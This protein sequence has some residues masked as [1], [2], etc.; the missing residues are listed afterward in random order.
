MHSL[1]PA[2]FKR[3][4]AAAALAVAT[5]LS[6]GVVSTSSAGAIALGEKATRDDLVQVKIFDK[7]DG[8]PHKC[9][10]TAIAPEWV[11]TA[12][13]CVE[14]P[15]Y[16][17]PDV[18]PDTLKIHFSNDKANPGPSIDVD[19]FEKAPKADIALLHLDTPK[20]LDKYAHI[21]DDHKYRDGEKVGFYGFGKGFKDVDV[22]WLH[23]ARMEVIAQRDNI[24]A[25]EVIAM[26]GITGG[27]NHGDSGGPVFT[28]DGQLIAV[29]VMGSHSV[30][31]D[32]YAESEAVYLKYYRDWIR[33]TA[34]V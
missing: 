1:I 18:S 12:A 17:D 24:N 4:C 13:H 30:W 5:A 23:K 9:T 32:P 20:K 2:R 11:L 31:F 25:G 26:Y 22:D 10:G 14:G 29:D 33:D 3:S 8:T 28:D 15:T 6:A 21:A 16:S 19:R 34:G 7:P 27:S